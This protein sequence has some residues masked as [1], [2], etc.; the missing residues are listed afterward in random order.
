MPSPRE[1]HDLS[2][3]A[4]GP[5]GKHLAGA[6]F[7]APCGDGSLIE[8]VLLPARF[9]G[10]VFPPRHAWDTGWYPSAADP[11]L[12]AWSTTHELGG[13]DLTAE[14]TWRSG[15]AAPARLHAAATF[16]NRSV[17]PVA[18]ELLLLARLVPP[19]APA[20]TLRLPPDALWLDALAYTESACPR[21]AHRTGQNVNARPPGAW[22]DNPGF[23]G[24]RALGPDFPR[25]P[26]E[27]VAYAVD[28]PAA[29][30]E[31]ALVVRYHRW[32]SGPCAFLFL[33]LAPEP[34]RFELPPHPGSA[35]GLVIL[36]LPPLPPGPRRLVLAGT[37]GDPVLLD[38]FAL[39]PRAALPD[40]A[41]TV[42]AP[43][44]PP[45]L[46][47]S[48]PGAACIRII[49]TASP[50]DLAL[51]WPAA[52]PARPRR[53]RADA[54]EDA[55]CRAFLDLV[56]DQV[57]GPGSANALVWNLGP[58][59]LAPGASAT[60][61]LAFAL[62][63]AAA[64]P[65][66]PPAPPRDPLPSGT[67]AGARHRPGAA[68]L[69]ATLAT[70]VTY[71]LSFRGS[72]VHAT[73]PGRFW[74]SFYTWDNGF[75]GLGLAVLD[76]ARSA[77]LLAAYLLPPDDP[78]AAFLEW[79][80]PLPTQFY[81]ALDLW[82]RTQDRALLAW[83]YPRLRATYEWFAGRARGSTTA[84]LPS[85]LLQTW[86]Y[87]YNSG[88]WD[89]Y[90]PQKHLAA[91]PARRARVAPCVTTSHAIR[92]AKILSALAR[93]LSTDTNAYA[94]DIARWT[95]AL[96]TRAWDPAAQLFS[97]VE[98]HAD[99]STSPLRTDE[100]VNFNHGLDA[101]QPL[102]AGAATPAQADALL[103]RLFDPARHWTPHGPDTVDRSAPYH[104]DDGYWN[105]SVW[106]PHQWFLFK[107]LLDLGRPDQA[108]K[109]VSTAL[110]LWTRE[111]SA[112]RRCY[113]HF[114][115]R[116]GRGRGWHHFGALSSPA[117]LFH[118]AAFAEHRLSTGFDT[119]I[120][121]HPV[122]DTWILD[123]AAVAAP[124]ALWWVSPADTTPAVTLDD[125]PLVPRALA[126]RLWTFL[127]PPSAA[128]ARLVIAP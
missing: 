101:L 75:T 85:G 63:E 70:N 18:A 64:H 84:R 109:L 102:V 16:H 59:P 6:A 34:L 25:R 67:P 68:L 61:P 17:L 40:L 76:P 60:V 124:A 47:S 38:G 108:W 21:L 81:Q 39:L 27:H 93:I 90:P 87:H 14:F 46:V 112:S 52:L 115:A 12:Q 78:H 120:V 19:P 128:A 98:H 116:D 127:L 83:A 105:G 91:D 10:P 13:P 107:T 73:V 96:Q 35:F 106:L 20:A 111:T 97:Y 26:D 30:P 94:A 118:E 79:G 31:P 88:G 48:S 110:E 86:D 49:D 104:R 71:P 99:G 29:L 41:W 66:A 82:E 95:A 117:L 56:N 126:P 54:P 42:P 72:P 125:R 4:W 28:L 23:T 119:V 100:G 58:V 92:F 32:T 1:D 8:V 37:G 15:P 9:R 11:S 44:P 89:D 24:G 55:L 103:S 33:D 45:R 22:L 5:Y 51:A 74:N 57:T 69:A 62:G 65:P 3:P 2:L 121:D 77:E 53:V 80:T 114:S 43:P 50:L 123:V 113:E 122:S 7:P 36:P